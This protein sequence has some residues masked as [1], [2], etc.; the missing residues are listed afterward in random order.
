M[1]RPRLIVTAA[2]WGT[3]GCTANDPLLGGRCDMTMPL[4][5]IDPDPKPK[6]DIEPGA[7]GVRTAAAVDRYQKGTVK[8]STGDQDDLWH[9]Q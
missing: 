3:A 4:Q 5:V 8:G 7:D 9:L 2:P 1:L 6:S